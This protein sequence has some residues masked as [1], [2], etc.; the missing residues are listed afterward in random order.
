[1]SSPTRPLRRF[2]LEPAIWGGLLYGLGWVFADSY[3][4]TFGLS[5]EDAGFGFGPLVV[6]VAL[7]LAGLGVALLVV[8]N[9]VRRFSSSSNI[10]ADSWRF[11]VVGTGIIIFATAILGVALW[12]GARQTVAPRWLGVS[13]SLSLGIGLIIWISALAVRAANLTANP[14]SSRETDVPALSLLLVVGLIAS[15][16]AAWS[17]GQELADRAM[18]TTSISMPGFRQPIVRVQSPDGEGRILVECGRLLGQASGVVSVVDLE[19]QRVL[20]LSI[21]SGIVEQIKVCQ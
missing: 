3:F 10:T 11:R 13:L 6:R 21:E 7:L 18:T 16:G 8:W 12:I 20:R 15:G 14:S 5:P 19:S 9:I 2:L 4:G 17:L 1:M